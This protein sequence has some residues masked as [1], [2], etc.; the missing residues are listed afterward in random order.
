MMLASNVKGGYWW[1]GS[2]NWTFP[3]VS[4]TFCC[5]MTDGGRGAVWQNG[6][7]HRSGNE[8]KVH[9]WIPPCG[10]NGTRWHSLTLGGHLWRPNSGCE[11]SEAV[12]GAFQQWQQQ[13][14]ITSTGADFYKH[15]MQTPIQCWQK[16]RANGG[17]Y[18][19]KWC[20]VAE[21]L[22][23]SNSVTVFTVSAVV[24]MET[25]RNR[26]HYF[27]RDLQVYGLWQFLFTQWGPGKP[28]G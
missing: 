20:F 24:S 26:R 16:C 13:Q 27:W 2:R 17:G 8:A 14:W 10:K 12:G 1:Y 3:L 15:G 4:V 21:N 18:V 11:H 28:K 6:I 22:L 23:L 9:H 7:W 25:W 19:A 5:C